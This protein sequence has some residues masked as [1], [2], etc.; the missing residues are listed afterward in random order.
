M[1]SGERGGEERG[2]EVGSRERRVAIR[3]DETRREERIQQGQR[4]DEQSGA[5]QSQWGAI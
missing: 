5:E 3:G 1:R 4:G 2:R